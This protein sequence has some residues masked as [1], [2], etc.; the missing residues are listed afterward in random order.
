MR[1]VTLNYPEG[2]EAMLMQNLDKWSKYGVW[3][4]PPVTRKNASPIPGVFSREEK[5]AR[6]RR[7]MEDVRAGR[8]F[9]IEEL[10]KRMEKW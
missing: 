2:F 1:Q 10:P 9:D 3:A 4:E 8:V 5:I 7:S 6:V